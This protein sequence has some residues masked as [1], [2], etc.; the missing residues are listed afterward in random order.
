MALL[1]VSLL[2][3]GHQDLPRVGV[4]QEFQGQPLEALELL[5]QD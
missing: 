4:P 2:K 1:V 5:V 3:E